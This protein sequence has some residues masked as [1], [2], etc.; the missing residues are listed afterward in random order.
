[1]YPNKGNVYIYMTYMTF[2]Q[3]SWWMFAITISL[4][5]PGPSWLISFWKHMITSMSTWPIDGATLSL[6]KRGDRANRLE[7]GKGI[8]CDSGPKRRGDFLSGFAIIT[9]NNPKQNG[10][11]LNHQGTIP[12]NLWGWLYHVTR[13]LWW[14]LIFYEWKR[15]FFL[16]MSLCWGGLGKIPSEE[17]WNIIK[18]YR[19]FQ[20]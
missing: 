13:C 5:I 14:T 8:G 4:T 17:I 11:T 10:E 18:I 19:C 2:I 15:V 6:D 9:W 3:K 16:L 20:K 1:M 12:G 7:L